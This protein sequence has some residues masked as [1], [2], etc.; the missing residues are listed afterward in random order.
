MTI[1]GTKL[2]ANNIIR[3]ERGFL[4][5][6][7]KTMKLV[8]GI[9]D[10]RVTRRISLTD[11]TSKDLAALGHPYAARHGSRG[12]PIHDPYWSIHSQS[13]NLL[14]AK[15]SGTDKASV[16]TGQLKASAFVGIDDNS[17]PYA[18]NLIFGTS[19]MI[20]RD[21]LENSK[22]EVKD[23]TGAVIAKNLKNLVTNFRGR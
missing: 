16:S 4:N 9:L 18:V 3:F 10:R 21:F 14:R 19:K 11:H 22:S 12:T 1:S 15:R 6:V 23:Q 2:V 7:N 13:G 8:E 17:A 5:H 20:P